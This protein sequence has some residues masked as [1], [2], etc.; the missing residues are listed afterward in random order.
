MTTIKFRN[1]E[2]IVDKELTKVAY[3]KIFI[4][5]PEGCGCN[6]CKNFLKNRETIYPTEIK[7]LFNELG[8]DYKKESEICHYGRLED[9]LHYYGGWFHFKGK[10]IGKDCSVPTDPNAGD[11]ELTPINKEF[12]IG[13]RYQNELTFFSD[14]ENLVQIEFETKTPWTI[15]KNL[16]SE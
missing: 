2:L 5:G 1:W 11:F 13:F 14:K 9:G 10:F 8:I 6:D 15:E 16:E 3:D 12:S 4:G 7:N